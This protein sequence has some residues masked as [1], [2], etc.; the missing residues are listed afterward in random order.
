MKL[1]VNMILRLLY[2]SNLLAE[3]NGQIF[4]VMCSLISFEYYKNQV[5]KSI[6]RPITIKSSEYNVK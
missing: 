1:E 3:T 4:V 2:F 5:L 6:Y